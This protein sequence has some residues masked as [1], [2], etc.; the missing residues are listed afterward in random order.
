M[1]P[2][3]QGFTLIEVL[4]ALAI[5]AIALVALFKAI[6]QNIHHNQTLKDKTIG[7]FVAAQGMSM[8]QLGLI[9]PDARQEITQATP[10]F[11]QKWYWRIKMKPTPIKGMH[12]ITIRVSLKPA[13][14]FRDPLVG[15]L[16]S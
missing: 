9:K 5:I 16:Y 6:S 4:I 7:H 3:Q 1:K 12:E 15:Y 11:N 14:P 13:G 2:K 10:F 8:V